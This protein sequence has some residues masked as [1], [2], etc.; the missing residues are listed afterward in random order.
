MVGGVLI[1]LSVVVLGDVAIFIMAIKK[2]KEKQAPESDYE[3]EH[4]SDDKLKNY[5]DLDSKESD[6]KSEKESDQDSNE[7]SDRDSNEESDDK[8]DGD[9]LLIRLQS[10]LL[11]IVIVGLTWVIN[12]LTVI[13][14]PEDNYEEV[15]LDTV[16][17]ILNSFQGIFVY[18]ST[19]MSKLKA[20]VKWIR[21][22]CGGACDDDASSTKSTPGKGHDQPD[23]H[24]S[25]NDNTT[26]QPDSHKSSN[27]TAQ[28]QPDL[29]NS[30]KDTVQKATDDTVQSQPDHHKSTDD[31]AQNQADQHK[32]GGKTLQRFRSYVEI[33]ITPPP[34][35][36]MAPVSPDRRPSETDHA[37]D[38][39]VFCDDDGSVTLHLDIQRGNM[40]IPEVTYV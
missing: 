26:N 8:S 19:R 37:Y 22:F 38:N 5:S 24:N 21:L 10:A 3:M 20:L 27:D 36:S 28:N 35:T 7:E 13:Q 23:H 40:Y 30:T 4:L 33:D 9:D 2:E 31:T 16:F 17:V 1:P 12:F 18:V 15:S 25:T 11:F 34:G 32:S 39:V 29:K 6:D 14:T